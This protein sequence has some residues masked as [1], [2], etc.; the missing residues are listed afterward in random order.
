[1][2]DG[3]KKH[4]DSRD[5]L[6]A[7]VRSLV[8][9]AEGEPSSFQG[10]LSQADIKLENIDAVAYART[11]NFGDGRVSRLSP[12]IHHGALSLNEVRN[13]V[14]GTSTQ[15]EQLTKF[16]QE[17][18]WRDFW[19]RV[20]TQQPEWAWKDIEAIKQVLMQM[21]TLLSCLMILPMVALALPAWMPLFM[22]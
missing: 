8:P 19:Q 11:R 13:H 6:V 3:L 4:F 1:M 5:E 15:P 17:L 10:G 12:Y 22:N 20:L 16:I 9:W 21:I 18:A 2:R 14:L 7:F